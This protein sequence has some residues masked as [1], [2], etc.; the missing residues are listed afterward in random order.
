MTHHNIIHLGRR[1]HICSYPGCGET[2]GYKHLL[3]R[4][5]TKV[6]ATSE[7]SATLVSSEDDGEPSSTIEWITGTNYTSPSTH[8]NTRRA[9][10]PCP[11]PNGFE[12]KDPN[13]NELLQVQADADIGRCAFVFSR[14]Y[15][16]RRHLKADH[17]LELTKNE[18]D[19]WVR[20][21]R[22]E[23]SNAA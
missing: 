10:V 14:A 4:H 13:R 3:Q 7:F 9:L 15:D 11:W 23:H 12:P 22:E 6:H 1:D 21:W 18:M 2:F 5:T 8:R 17:G 19:E 16:L 20:N